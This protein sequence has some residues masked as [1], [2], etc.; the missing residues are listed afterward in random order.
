MRR[1]SLRDDQ[2]DRIKDFHALAN[3]IDPPQL[4]HAS[5]IDQ[6]G[7][8]EAAMD[9]EPNNSH[10]LLL[11]FT[12]SRSRRGNTTTTHPRSQAQPGRSQGRSV[13]CVS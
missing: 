9:I 11:P 7:L 1:Y 13:T 10:V 4:L 3:E 2:W 8:R 6:C 12:S 5:L